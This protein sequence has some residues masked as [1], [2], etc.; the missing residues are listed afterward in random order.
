VKLTEIYP[1]DELMTQGTRAD[2]VQARRTIKL[3]LD[4]HD[5]DPHEA[6]YIG[7]LVLSLSQRL[8]VPNDK[9]Q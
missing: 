2:L 1:G 8:P 3:W 4:G 5:M 6:H 7:M 9:E